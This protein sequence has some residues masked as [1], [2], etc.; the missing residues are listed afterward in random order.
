MN[1]CVW[2][3][4]KPYKLEICHNIPS[5]FLH[6]EVVAKIQ[7]STLKV[8]VWQ[9]NIQSWRICHAIHNVVK[10]NSCTHSRNWKCSRDINRY[11]EI[12]LTVYYTCH[13][14]IWQCPT[15]A[16]T[17]SHVSFMTVTSGIARIYKKG[18]LPLCSHS[19]PSLYSLPLEVR[20]P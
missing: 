9:C 1:V 6:T 11:R 13:I 20:S 10:F 14:H 15:V 19:L 18:V 5:F 4:C 8:F 12:T 17:V 16:H 7:H 3:V 2:Y